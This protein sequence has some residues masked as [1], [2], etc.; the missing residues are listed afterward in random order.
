L[1]NILLHATNVVLLFTLI[2]KISSRTAAFVASIF[3]LVMPIHTESIA[4]IAARNGLLGTFFILIALLYLLNGEKWKASSVF[5]LAL[6]S[7]DTAITFL[8]LAG[9]IIWIT[10]E[11]LSKSFKQWFWYWWPLAVYFPLR[12]L[13]LGRYSF[14]GE[15]F[16]DPVIGPLAFVS[17]LERVQTGFVHLFLYLRKTFIPTDLSPD[18]SYNQIPVVHGFFSS[19][20]SWVGLLVFLVAIAI[21]LFSRRRDLRIAAAL[22]IIPFAVISNIFFVTT[23]TMAER[24]WYM[25]SIGVAWLIG[26]AVNS[27][28]TK[29]PRF[30]F[31]VIAGVIFVSIAYALFIP[32]QVA[33]WK[34]NSTLFASAATRSPNSVWAHTNLAEQYFSDGDFDAAEREVDLSMK[35]YDKNVTTLYVAGKLKWRRGNLQD[36][37]TLF[38][39]AIIADNHGRNKRSLNRILAL[40]A[41][42]QKE[43]QSA[44]EHMQEAINWPVAG[45]TATITAVDAHLLEIFN[46]HLSPGGRYITS[47][48]KQNLDLVLK[49][50]RGF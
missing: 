5:L 50:V 1:I 46:R 39:Q 14:K 21:I 9:T 17:I 43:Y 2:K 3:F 41:F 18:Y 12:W 23:G 16:I 19:L 25:P 15:G 32:G 22:F 24:W 4:S 34:S 7:A 42:E 45:D 47:D 8:P 33:V 28:I 36:A 26:V 37:R 20:S 29:F 31:T 27:L 13:A 30:R 48:E 10:T 11:D 35:I 49:S 38:E 44:A 40:L 6:L